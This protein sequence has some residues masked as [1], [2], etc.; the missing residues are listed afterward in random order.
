MGT[1]T[2][3][4]VPSQQRSLIALILR[5]TIVPI[6]Y[7][8]HN[9]SFSQSWCIADLNLITSILHP[10]YHNN[11]TL[12]NSKTRLKFNHRSSLRSRCYLRIKLPPRDRYVE[13]QRLMGFKVGDE[14]PEAEA[15]LVLLR[16]IDQNRKVKKPWRELVGKKRGNLNLPSKIP[17]SPALIFGGY[18]VEKR[19]SPLFASVPRSKDGWSSDLKANFTPNCSAPL[20]HR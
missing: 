9:S 16:H 12:S 13:Q 3:S 18:F 19:G 10:P 1:F 17:I 7:L 11:L 20:D 6:S 2:Y 4:D 5:E 15:R 14:T 8:Q